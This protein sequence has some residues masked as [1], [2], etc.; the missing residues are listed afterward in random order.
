MENEI[1]EKRQIVKMSESTK[2]DILCKIT[3][4]CE[5]L[6]ISKAELSRR[7]GLST[8]QQFNNIIKRD[9]VSIG[10]LEKI[11]TAC[12]CSVEIKFVPK[13]QKGEN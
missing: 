13:T 4:L 6:G 12:D 11:A 2:N 7:I 3:N 8:P 10:Y 1:K 5:M 9:E